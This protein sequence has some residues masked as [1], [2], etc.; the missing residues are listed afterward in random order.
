MEEA[1]EAPEAT[2]RRPPPTTK[3]TPPLPL[4]S[5]T[6]TKKKLVKKT[7]IKTTSFPQELA[8]TRATK[9][10]TAATNATATTALRAASC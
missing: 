3:K 5:P 1:R 7:A 4:R 8:T 10:T 6:W 2:A 9:L